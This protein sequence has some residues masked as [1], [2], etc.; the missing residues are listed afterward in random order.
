M[1]CLITKI[2]S[3]WVLREFT[4]SYSIKLNFQSALCDV[5]GEDLE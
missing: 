4:H 1:I 5:A 2:H 3:F